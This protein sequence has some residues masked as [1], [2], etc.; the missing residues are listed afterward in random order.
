MSIITR[1]VT[2]H[3]DENPD[4]RNGLE[5]EGNQKNDLEPFGRLEES[6]KTIT[7]GGASRADGGIY[8]LI[9][10]ESNTSNTNLVR[11]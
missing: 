9:G 1:K 11:G 6:P 7:A 2:G 4:D 10:S 5:D 3:L 8:M